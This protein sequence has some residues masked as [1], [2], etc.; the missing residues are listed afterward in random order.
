MQIPFI[1]L[2]SQYAHIADDV[3]AAIKTVLDHGKYLMGPEVTQLE[4]ELAQYTGAKHVITCSSGT[5]ALVMALMALD[6][7]PGDAVITTPFTFFA[8]VEAISLLGAT[9]IFADIE[10]HSY[11]IDPVEIEKAIK[12]CPSH[13]TV[14]AIM[15]VDLFGQSCDYEEIN[16]I[17]KKHGLH[18]IADAAQSFGSTYKGKTCGNLSDI[19]ATSFYPSKP[20]SC[21][22]DGG[23]VFLNDDELATQ[24]RSI[25]IHG[26]S[27]ESKYVNQRIGLT[28]RLDTIQAAIL[29]QKLPLLDDELSK[30]R[31]FATY[32]DQKL[33]SL[34]E[35]P[36]INPERVSAWAHYSILVD[37]P[38]ALCEHLTKHSIPFARYYPVPM[39]LQAAMTH[40]GH[41]KGAF[42]VS[43]ITADRILSLPLHPYMT[44]EQID[45][46][47]DKVEQFMVSR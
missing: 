19:T 35:R 29:L 27:F 10:A 20:L 39:H 13:L 24:L 12:N 18:C 44:H 40:L 47:V 32:Y 16:A 43:E 46:I 36:L 41:E 26:Q 3:Q 15:P 31:Q 42:P 25:R 30:R 17:A 38:E 6:I 4:Q 11:L 33:G 5:D 14:K 23:A 9:P 1:D 2:K 37:D 45:Y 21:Y 34:V 22:G 7:G 28:A 8:T